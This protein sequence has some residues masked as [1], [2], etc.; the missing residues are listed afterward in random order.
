MEGRCSAPSGAEDPRVKERLPRKWTTS[1]SDWQ[2]LTETTAEAISSSLKLH[3]WSKVIGKLVASR[4]EFQKINAEIEDVIPV[5]ELENEYE[6]VAHYD[7]QALERLVCLRCC[8]E[9][10]I[11]SKA[12]QTS[13]STTINVSPASTTAASQNFG[14]NLPPLTIKPIYSIVCRIDTSIVVNNLGHP[15]TI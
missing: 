14:P 2:F 13:I 10:L 12:W 7:D 4:D 15:C 1:D 11:L 9:E 8:P 6:S 5:E 3:P